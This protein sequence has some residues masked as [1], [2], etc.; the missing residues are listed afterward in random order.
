MRSALV[1][2]PMF[3]IYKLREGWEVK[4]SKQ[5]ERRKK[6]KKVKQKEIK[7]PNT[8]T[9]GFSNMW[10]ERGYWMQWKSLHVYSLSKKNKGNPYEHVYYVFN[11]HKCYGRSFCIRQSIVNIR[12]YSHNERAKTRNPDSNTHSWNINFR[13]SL[14]VLSSIFSSEAP[15]TSIHL[16]LG[17]KIKW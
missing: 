5:R 16:Y 1:P 14:Q 13:K 3:F 12:C 8:V 6:K 11:V 9:P 7:C 4:G 17:W 15:Y 10:I 2:S